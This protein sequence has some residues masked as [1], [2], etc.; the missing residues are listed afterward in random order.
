[1]RIVIAIGILIALA[2]IGANYTGSFDDSS[3]SQ[4]T[5]PQ[6]KSE[7]IFHA[8]E[9]KGIK[10]ED[11]YTSNGSEIKEAFDLEDSNIEDNSMIAFI[12]FRYSIQEDIDEKLLS[13]LGVVYT[14]LSAEP[15]I[16]GVLVMPYDPLDSTGRASLVYTN[17]SHAQ[18]V[19]AQNLP[20]RNFYNRFDVYTITVGV[21]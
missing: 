15:S 13:V 16:D 14:A 1:M 20:L 10:V 18:E 6:N 19:A 2:V 12:V 5:P 11:V 4:S 7:I 9:E 3:E 21:K 17:R 8:I